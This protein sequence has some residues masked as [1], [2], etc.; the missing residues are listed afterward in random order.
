MYFT[1]QQLGLIDAGPE[2]EFDNLTSLAAE[3][4][5]VP[6]AHVSILDPKSKRIF[7]KSQHGHPDELANNRELPMELTYCQHVALNQ[8]PVII[9]DASTHPLVKDL[10]AQSE[11]SPLA[12]MGLPIHAP[13]GQ[14]LGGLCMLQPEPRQWTEGEIASAK[15]LAAC[16]SDL[17][18]LKAA[19]LTSEQLRQEQRQFTYA[20]SHDLI[21]PANTLRMILDEVGFESDKLS[22]DV[23]KFLADGQSTITRMKQQV[24]DVLQYSRSVEINESLET[25]SIGLLVE[26]ILRD[27]QGVIHETRASISV[28]ELPDI[29]GNRMQ[30]RAL[31]KNLIGNALKYRVAERCPIVSITATHEPHRQ[32]SIMVEDNGIGVAPKDQASIFELFTRLH[33][34]DDYAGTGIGLAL[35]YRVAENHGGNIFVTSDGKQGSIFTLNLPDRLS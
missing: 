2:V 21:S 32:H 6:V 22:V 16:V 3:L 29:W 33:V 10:A 11:E 31:L 23:Q 9:V 5:R 20:I 28:G 34:Q 1:L 19:M 25:I 12:Y 35:C 7:Y 4:L 24:E 14:V 17:I 15:K 8:A 30:I 18:R 27:L 26:D 13:D